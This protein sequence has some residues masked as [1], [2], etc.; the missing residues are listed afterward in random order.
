MSARKGLLLALVLARF[1]CGGVASFA[2]PTETITPPSLVTPSPATYPSA[3]LARGLGAT[4][5]LELTVDASGAVVDAT[6]ARV[7]LDPP[8]EP[9]E[10]AQGGAG[11][12][13]SSFARAALAAS[14]KL[15]F[16]PGRLGEK[17]IVV[18]V[19]YAYRFA[20]PA[21]APVPTSRPSS[22][23][24][25]RPAPRPASPLYGRLA[26]LLRQRGSRDRLAG[27]TVRVFPR[28][29]DGLETISDARGRFSFPRLEAG[30]WR[31]ETSAEGF[32]PFRGEETIR[33][34]EAVELTMFLE[35][36]RFNPY[37]VQ[38]V[39]ARP[40]KEVV[41]RSL[42]RADIVSVPGTL[43]DPVQVVGNL[44]GVARPSTG[45]GDL[46]VR[47]SG[48]N[49]TGVFIDSIGVPIIYHFGG[50]R[51][52]IPAEMI[53]TVDFYPGNFGVRYGRATGGI[54][55]LNLR[56]LRPRRF[57][58][59]IDISLLDAGIYLQTPLGENAALAVAGRR[60]YLDAF[61]SSVI[62]SDVA[63]LTTAPV[64]YDYQSLFEWRPA[65]AHRIK[66]FFMG[67]SD[68][69]RLLF[70][71][72][73]EQNV[74]LQS[75]NTNLSTLFHRGSVEYLYAPSERFS[76][77]LQLSAGHDATR[78]GFGGLF[79][80]RSDT[81]TLELRDDTALRLGQRA[82]LHL[83]VDTRL[84][85]QDIEVLAPR[86][87]REGQGVVNSA[88]NN[89]DIGA[90][91]FTRVEGAVRVLAAPFV[92]AE[93]ELLPGLT[94]VPGVR[95][96]Y[97]SQVDALGVDP[98]LTAAYRLSPSWT[99]KAGAA[100]V[101]QPPTA[102]ET[103]DSFGNPELGLQRALQ[104]SA[105]LGWQPLKHLSLDATVF[106]KDLG[107][108]VSS[109]GA[110]VERDGQFVPAVYD[111][112]GRGKVVGLELFADHRFNANFRGWVSY[113]LMSARRTDSGESESR[114]FD[115][116][117]RHILN[118]VASYELPQNWRIGLRWRF[119]SG[120]PYTPVSGSTFV[121]DTDVYEPIAGAL[122]SGRL[123]AFH[124]LD[125]RLDKRWLFDA[126]R[127][128]AYISLTNAYAHENSEGLSYS[129]DFSQTG[130][131]SGLPILPIVGMQGEF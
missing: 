76:H 10:A 117:Q 15:K 87:P 64:Y 82:T 20:P 53:G 90:R 115:F 105:G 120:N 63:N 102:Q 23:P 2:A 80:F 6:V 78:L 47:G 24:E 56:P 34:H 43:G 91:V 39:A 85:L 131:V 124:Q 9:P 19:R 72:P 60:S 51:S 92:E 22:S 66:A 45:S 65:P 62:P 130:T 107:G 127:L 99:V 21:P 104:L 48:P 31:V 32:L 126:W 79:R 77:S 26:G 108:L 93:L 18:R 46:L 12:E 73:Q 33:P 11:A 58:G 36:G 1:L 89:S 38:V 3:A 96:E 110:V 29:G 41:R 95:L 128:T 27:V 25:A 61:L 37:D 42:D 5:E 123:P 86:P 13:T 55:N 97:F 52:V 122:N 106:Y 119:V 116:D 68:A 69:L 16:T 4:V 74:Q 71:N 7:A 81:T 121:S 103:D 8:N 57:G 17:A 112:G 98:R 88:G 101:H 125:L 59:S 118:V 94:L 40:R 35:R 70:Q 67:S 54:L 44:P 114:P 50:L 75:G 113:T 28:R 49:D 84:Q 109:T 111:N 14:R 30:T 83:G 100:L 129:Y